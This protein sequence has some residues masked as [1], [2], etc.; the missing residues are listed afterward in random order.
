M[1]CY[2]ISNPAVWT[3]RTLQNCVQPPPGQTLVGRD[4][5]TCLTVHRVQTAKQ[6]EKGLKE[7]FRE[8]AQSNK[9]AFYDSRDCLPSTFQRT[10][11]ERRRRLCSCSLPY[12]RHFLCLHC[13]KAQSRPVT[14]NPSRCPLR[15]ASPDPSTE[16]PPVR[17]LAFPS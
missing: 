5:N 3:Q 12:P 8:T 7:E 1:H 4:K 10:L 14:P 2:S 15:D 9:I 16:Q 6:K 17:P 13:A 11:R